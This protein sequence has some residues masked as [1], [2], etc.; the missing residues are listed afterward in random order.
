MAVMN[1]TLPAQWRMVAEKW[2]HSHWCE[3]IMD[4]ALGSAGTKDLNN[5][6]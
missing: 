3:A 2:A 1:A 5:L 4:K 6:P